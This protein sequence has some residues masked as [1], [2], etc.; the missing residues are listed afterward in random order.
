MNYLRLDSCFIYLCPGGRMHTTPETIIQQISLFLEKNKKLETQYFLIKNLEYKLVES[1]LNKEHQEIG[2]IILIYKL[3]TQA[4]LETCLRLSMSSG[5]TLS[6][7]I[8]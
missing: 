3:K 6:L 2:E 7:G 1:I 5:L 8:K 4:A